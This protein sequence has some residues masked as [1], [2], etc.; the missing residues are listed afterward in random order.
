MERKRLRISWFG[1]ALIILGLALLLDRFHILR[2]DFSQIFWALVMMFGIMKVVG[3]F[4]GNIRGRIFWGTVLFL[5][6]LFF[7]LRSID[8]IEIH[9]HMLPPA[10][11]LIFGIAFFMMFLNDARDW[12]FIIPAVLLIGVGGAFTLTEFGYLSRWEV[13][14]AVRLYWPV[15]L[16]L[17]GLVLIMRRRMRVQSGQTG[18][19][20]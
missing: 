13:W 15:A 4:S 9:A 16:I 11:F 14:E 3:G 7:L 2:V 1:V 20:T 17:L 12:H 19:Q 5:F 6:G 10:A 18:P 8:R